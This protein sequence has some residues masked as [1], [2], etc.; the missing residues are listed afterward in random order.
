MLRSPISRTPPRAA[1]KAPFLSPKAARAS[2]ARKGD[3]NMG[4]IGLGPRASSKEE[5]KK[6]T[7]LS[8]LSLEIS[9]RQIH[10]SYEEGVK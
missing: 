3:H 7:I 2:R 9:L 5:V 4:A 10:E 6:V 1:K 8:D